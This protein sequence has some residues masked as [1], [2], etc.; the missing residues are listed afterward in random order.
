MLGVL[1]LAPGAVARV[2]RVLAGAVILMTAAVLGTA[3]TAHA[4][5]L[6]GPLPIGPSL[7]RG[8]AVRDDH[9]GRCRGSG[10]GPG[11]I[12]IHGRG[13]TSLRDPLGSARSH[14]CI[15]IDNAAIRFL[16]AHVPD[17]SPVEIT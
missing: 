12:A 8:A 7:S 16:A 11:R 2:V 17:G 1:V 6:P 14:G 5:W 4:A 13:S 9:G 10:R 15:R 3:A